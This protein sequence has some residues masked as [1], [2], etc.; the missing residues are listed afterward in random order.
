MY[1]FYICVYIHLY[2]LLH[3]YLYV[4]VCVYICIYIHVYGLLKLQFPMTII[5]IFNCRYYIYVCMYACIH[6]YIYIYSCCIYMCI[7]TRTRPAQ[8]TVLGDNYWQ[9]LLL[10][11]IFVIKGNLSS[12][13][14]LMHIYINVCTYVCV[15]IYTRIRPAQAAVLGDIY[16]DFE[17][18]LLCTYLNT[19][20]RIYIY[21][22]MCACMC[23][24]MHIYNL[25][26]LQHSV[27]IIA[28]FNRGYYVHI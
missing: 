8:A 22:Y 20:T 13:L 7:I 6:V 11:A 15:C 24:Y 26:T 9:S 14:L 5:A 28:I 25:L 16:C 21:L 3:I 17:S 10:K 27:T 1:V 4:C 23:V 19:H 2:D 12:P 18:P